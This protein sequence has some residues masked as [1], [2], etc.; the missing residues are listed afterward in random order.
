MKKNIGEI[1]LNTPNIPAQYVG[2]TKYAGFRE[3]EHSRFFSNLECSTLFYPGVVM[4]EKDKCGKFWP[5]G[6]VSA[7]LSGAGG[8]KSCCEIWEPSLEQPERGA[9]NSC[10]QHSSEGLENLA[11][12]K[13]V[14]LDLELDWAE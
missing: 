12:C 3:I 13:R 4:A 6:F 14:S 11:E 8:W 1:H 9:S 7:Q 2:V 10:K 5:L